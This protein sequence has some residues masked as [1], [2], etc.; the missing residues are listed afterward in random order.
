MEFETGPAKT[1]DGYSFFGD[2]WTNGG[3]KRYSFE[4]AGRRKQPKSKKKAN[5]HD[6]GGSRKLRVDPSLP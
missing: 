2:K 4:T 6:R 5:I 1:A 3:R